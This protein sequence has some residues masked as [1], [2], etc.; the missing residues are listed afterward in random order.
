MKNQGHHCLLF[1][2]VA[3]KQ[4]SNRFTFGEADLLFVSSILKQNK[5]AAIC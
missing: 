4:A 5:M 1:Y 3:K 2:R